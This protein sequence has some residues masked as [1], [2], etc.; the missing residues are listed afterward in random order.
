MRATASRDGGRT[1]ESGFRTG[2][3]SRE[4][5]PTGRDFAGLK[6]L[7]S[8]ESWICKQEKVLLLSK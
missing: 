6:I 5:S 4:V 7:L 3:K 8:E 2:Q 1:G